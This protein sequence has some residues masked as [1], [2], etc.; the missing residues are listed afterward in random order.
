MR[1]IAAVSGPNGANGAI[2]DFYD[3]FPDVNS[4]GYPEGWQAR[5]T[6]KWE[7]WMGPAKKR[8]VK[9]RP[10][11]PSTR[12]LPVAKLLFRKR[13]RIC[14]EIVERVSSEEEEEIASPATFSSSI[15]SCVVSLKCRHQEVPSPH[16]VPVPRAQHGRRALGDDDH[17]FLQMY[18]PVR[19]GDPWQME[20]EP[21]GKWKLDELRILSI[22]GCTL[23]V[24]TGSARGAVSVSDCTFASA[25][26]AKSYMR[27]V[28]LMVDLRKNR[29]DRQ[30]LRYNSQTSFDGGIG[31]MQQHATRVTARSSSSVSDD[32]T[33]RLLIEIVSATDLPDCSPTDPYVSVRIGGKGIH[34]TSVL[35]KTTNPIWTLR[36]GGL[37]VLTATPQEFFSAYGGMVFS[38]YDFNALVP[39][40]CLG[41]VFLPLTKLLEG[42]GMRIGY[43]IAHPSGEFSESSSGGI[44]GSCGRLY[45]RFREATDYD[46]EFLRD[47][48]LNSGKT[49]VYS[50]DSH[51]SLR[52]PDY[53]FLKLNRM[54]GKGGCKLYRVKPYP[55]P[56]RK[57]E[58]TWMTAEQIQEESMKPSTNFVEAGSGDLGKLYVEVI[59]ASDL[60]NMD[61]GI[62]G[63]QTDAFACLVF[64][65]S[66]VNTD[67]I[68]R[69]LSPR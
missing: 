1:G 9:G 66:I 7:V 31:D 50:K 30:L 23:E 40:E 16:P 12:N 21:C 17:V 59:G 22:R 61:L 46:I 35:P 15:S 34:Q 29:M 8:M 33:I 4:D 2:L 45:L 48:E 5:S 49:G 28:D 65:D 37:F 51:F 3:A 56:A 20:W 24:E 11:V 32:E 14:L 53:S 10:V 62:I 55:D 39:D 19:N 25:E 42:T 58:T 18:R 44:R 27:L 63:D 67:V 43:D 41:K 52:P 38:V 47:F 68:G 6:R 64:E 26:E 69:C 60:P 36:K 54:V 13:R 57:E